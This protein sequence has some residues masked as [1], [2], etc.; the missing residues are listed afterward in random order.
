MLKKSEA[1]AMQPEIEQVVNKT[2][3]IA[4]LLE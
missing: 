2:K 4:H 3:Q 1:E